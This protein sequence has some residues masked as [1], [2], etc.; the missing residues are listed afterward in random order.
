[1]VAGQKHF[2]S[3]AAAMLGRRPLPVVC[4]IRLLEETL[5]R[6][7]ASTFA[8]WSPWNDSNLMT[9]WLT[10]GAL[11]IASGPT[12]AVKQLEIQTSSPTGWQ[13]EFEES[14]LRQYGDGQG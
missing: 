7:M 10:P 1:M 13:E 9:L 2:L 12:K 4:F 11:E 3:L 6:R 5:L 8:A 14:V